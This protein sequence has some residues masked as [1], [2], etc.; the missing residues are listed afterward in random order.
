MHPRTAELLDYCDS[1]IL[2]LRSAVDA[3]PAE[4]R[5]WRPSPTAWSTNDV[6]AHLTIMERRL[7]GVLGGALAEAR[8]RGLRAE[9]DTSPIMP[10]VDLSPVLDR[11]TKI[12]A[13]DRVDPRHTGDGFTWADFEAARNSVRALLVEHD[14]MALGDLSHPHPIFGPLDFYHWFA[15]VGAHGTRHAAQ[16]L[17]IANQ[18]SLAN[19]SGGAAATDSPAGSASAR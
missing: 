9:S 1:Q 12:T 19:S 3:M 11:T 14:G 7:A 4:R 13:P 16:I 8:A 10:Q 6:I 18:W 2:H 17:E 5:D 15:F